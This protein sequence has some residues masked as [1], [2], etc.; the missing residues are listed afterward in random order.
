VGGLTPEVEDVDPSASVSSLRSG[1]SSTSRLSKHD[2][3]TF[4]GDMDLVRALLAWNF[5]SGISSGLLGLA[6][7]G[8]SAD[9]GEIGTCIIS[10]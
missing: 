8:L 7:S 10:S 2:G 5:E 4:C 3:I 6:P 9:I 1:G